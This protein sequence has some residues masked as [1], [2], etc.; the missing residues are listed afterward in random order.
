[1]SREDTRQRELCRVPTI[2]H[3]EK[4]TLYRVPTIGSRQ[5]LT[6]VSFG[7]AADDPLP[8]APFVE[9][10]ILGKRVFAEWSPVPSVQH[11]VKLGS[12]RA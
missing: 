8:S 11:S 6:N 10:L 7:T 3:L 2:W 4:K 12:R 5:R 9:C 1:V